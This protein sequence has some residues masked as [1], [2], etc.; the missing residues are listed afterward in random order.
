MLKAQLKDQKGF[1]LVELIVVIAIMVILIAM[2]VPNVIGYI[3]KATIATEKSAAG[4]VY[5]SAQAYLTDVYA[6]GKAGSYTGT[7]PISDVVAAELL[8]SSQT[9][10]LSNLSIAITNAVVTQVSFDSSTGKGKIV[11]KSGGAVLES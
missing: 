2:L 5:S 3:N 10:K 11:Y 4:T 6:D 1:S 8:E 9:E 7:L